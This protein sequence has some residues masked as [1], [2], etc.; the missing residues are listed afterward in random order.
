MT[1]N[2]L[3]F[4]GLS[5]LLISCSKTETFI[6]FTYPDGKYKA[7]IMSYDDGVI[8]DIQLIKLFDQHKIKGTFNLNSA[9]LGTTRGWAQEYGDSVFQKYIPIDSILFVYKNHVH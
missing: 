2:V 1:K 9:Y 8:Q 5:F 3:L 4:L 6:N 7:L